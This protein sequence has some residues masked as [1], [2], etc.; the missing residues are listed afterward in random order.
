MNNLI[1]TTFAEKCNQIK[2]NVKKSIQR[3]VEVPLKM[4]EVKRNVLLK[5]TKQNPPPVV[6][7]ETKT[8]TTNYGEPRQNKLR[9]LKKTLNEIKSYE[10]QA[11]RSLQD[12]SQNT[13]EIVLKQV[14]GINKQYF[15]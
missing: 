15:S 8:S 13:Q 5:E 1:K 6:L 4:S 14:I 7:P 9:D 3:N 12:L 10:A 2:S 11:V